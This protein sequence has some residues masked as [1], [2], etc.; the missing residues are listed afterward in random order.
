MKEREIKLMRHRGSTSS[1]DSHWN[2]FNHVSLCSSAFGRVVTVP[3]GATTCYAVFTDKD[4]HP[5]STLTLKRPDGDRYNR[6]GG[7]E[8]TTASLMWGPRRKLALMYDRGYRFV[9]FEFDAE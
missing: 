2:D 5:D 6:L 8:E 9:R 7:V 1:W 3:R 4:T